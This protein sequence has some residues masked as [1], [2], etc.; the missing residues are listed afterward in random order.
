MAGVTQTR[1]T[2]GQW[3]GRL[4]KTPRGHNTRPTSSKVRQALFDILGPRIEGATV[5][6]LF[7]GAGT[8]SFEA[9]S[10][11]AAR[12]TLVERERGVARLI[13]ATCVALK[14]EDQIEIEVADV[15]VWL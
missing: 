15:T 10:R 9:L 6:D 5:L 14:C 1:I 2:A 12:A 3:R 11:G 8:F 13:A 4:I 7:A